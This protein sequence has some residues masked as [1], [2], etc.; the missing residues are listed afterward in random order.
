MNQQE[1]VDDALLAKFLAGEATPEEA[2]LVTDWI[3][4]SEENKRLFTQSQQAWA[5][6]DE[7]VAPMEKSKIL[8]T[9][10]QKSTGKSVEFFTPL[11]IAAAIT[12]I[13]ACVVGYY[14]IPN[15]P[16]EETWITKNTNEEVSKFNLPEGTSIALN[17]N[18]KISYPKAFDGQTRTVKLSGEALFDVVHNP[19]QPF[20]VNCDEINVKVLGTA[21]NITNKSASVIETQV[22]RGKVAMYTADQSINIEAG[23]IGSYDKSTRKLSLRKSISENKI[24]YATHTFTFEDTSLKQVTDNLSESYGVSFIFEN[25][26]I[27][28][29]HLT[30][31]YN[32]KSL[33]FILDVISESLN[34]KYTVKG[35]I[36]YLSGDGCL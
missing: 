6:E 8:S 32:D 7:S 15:T 13:A 19:E 16:V 1:I 17:R 36:V 26:K 30:S 35:N 25:D 2:M 33:S 34:V 24:G 31:S 10:T 21:F 11:R 28:D 23:W 5:M 18:S 4:A 27:K 9:I 12:L 29:C 14:T 3:D 20:I 22:T